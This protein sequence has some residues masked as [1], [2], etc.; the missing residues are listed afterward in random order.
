MRKRK[1]LGSLK[2]FSIVLPHP[3]TRPTNISMFSILK[4]FSWKSMFN[5]VMQQNEMSCI[6]IL[7]FTDLIDLA[8]AARRANELHNMI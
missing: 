6:L 3:S 4:L 5:Y 7:R 1:R 2:G 8:L